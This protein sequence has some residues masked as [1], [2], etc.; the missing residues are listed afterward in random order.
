MEAIY[1]VETCSCLSGRLADKQCCVTRNLES[2]FGVDSK[3][4]LYGVVDHPGGSNMIETH[5]SGG[6]LFSTGIIS[7]H[8]C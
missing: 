4:Y 6:C 3:L 1:E 5:L 7:I 2:Q 8:A